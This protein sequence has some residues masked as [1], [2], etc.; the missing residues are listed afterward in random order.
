MTETTEKQEVTW[1]IQDADMMAAYQHFLY[2]IDVKHFVSTVF[3]D[4]GKLMIDHQLDKFYGYCERHGGYASIRAIVEFIQYNFTRETG[5][6]LRLLDYLR[7]NH[8]HKW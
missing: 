7:A 8:W 5:R 2:Y 6:L 3:E 4:E 1:S